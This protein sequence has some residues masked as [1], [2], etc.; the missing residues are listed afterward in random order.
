MLYCELI[1]DGNLS[2]NNKMV[3]SDKKIGFTMTIKIIILILI[4]FIFT[5]DSLFIE[6][7]MLR[8]KKYTLHDEYLKG[9]KPE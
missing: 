8:V 4:L 3:L 7:N 9:K 1:L 2:G 6:P 5:I